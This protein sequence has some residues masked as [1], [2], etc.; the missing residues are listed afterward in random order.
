MTIQKLVLMVPLAPK[1]NWSQKGKK[2]PFLY[3]FINKLNFLSNATV[4]EKSANTLASIPEFIGWNKLS[5]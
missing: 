5:S 4:L 1:F 3:I 2:I